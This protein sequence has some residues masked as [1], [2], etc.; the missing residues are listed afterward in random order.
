M[1]MLMASVMMSTTAW[2]PMMLVAFAMA[3]AQSM[4]VAVQ[5]FLLGIAIATAMKTTRSANAGATVKPTTMPMAF[6]TMSTTVWVNW[7]RVTSAM[8]LEPFMSADVRHPRG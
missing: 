5:T 7:M 8:A 6:A 3:Q 4:S 1:Q 2:A